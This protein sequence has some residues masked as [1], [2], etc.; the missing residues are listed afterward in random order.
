MEGTL[1]R[2][3]PSGNGNSDVVARLWRSADGAVTSL[4]G[5]CGLGGTA[6]AACV[7]I[8]NPDFAHRLRG[9]SPNAGT[10]LLQAL[11]QESGVCGPCTRI[12][13]LSTGV[14]LFVLTDTLG[15]AAINSPLSSGFWPR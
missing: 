3:R 1:T 7:R 9:A 11:G 6:L 10:F 14:A 13:A 8:P 12:P 5:G 15:N 2:L 4:G